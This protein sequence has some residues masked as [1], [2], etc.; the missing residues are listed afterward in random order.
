MDPRKGSIGCTL[1]GTIYTAPPD[2]KQ[3]SAC[4]KQGAKLF[5]IVRGIWECSAVECPMR[6]RLTAQPIGEMSDA[7]PS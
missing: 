1:G 7:D 2:P 4:G 3:C 5:Q 6:K